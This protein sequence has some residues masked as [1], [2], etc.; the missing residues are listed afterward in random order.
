MICNNCGSQL[1]IGTEQVGVDSKGLPVI[2]RFGYCD[3]CRTKWDLDLP[4]QPRKSNGNAVKTTRMVIGIISLVLTLIILFQSCAAGVVNTI[5]NNGDVG[6]SAGFLLSI[7]MIVGGILGVVCR[8]QKVGS[9]VA[10]CFYAFGGLVGLP[11]SST[12]KDLIVWSVISIIFAAVF[13]ITGAIQKE[14]YE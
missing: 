7:C 9:I 4:S 14:K 3:N 11:N 12:Y 10:G 2:H 1:R 5:E 6:G 13:I 8:K